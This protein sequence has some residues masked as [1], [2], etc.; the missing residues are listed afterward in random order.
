MSIL[1]A[2]IA[3]GTTILSKYATCMGNFN[4]VIEQVLSRISQENSR[5]T[6]SDNWLII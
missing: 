2:I 4:E 3:R 6:Y 1:F 5:L